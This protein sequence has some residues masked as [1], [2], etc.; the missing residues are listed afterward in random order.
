[1]MRSVMVASALVLLSGTAVLA[2]IREFATHAHGV[3]ALNVAIE[4]NTIFMELTAPAHDIVGFEYEAVSDEDR[5][6]ISRALQALSDPL[7]IFAFPPA[8]ECAAL[9]AFADLV[10]DSHDDDEHDDHD[11]RHDHDVDHDDDHHQR[12]GGGQ[13][14]EFHVRYVVECEELGA[15]RQVAVTYF[16]RFTNAERLEVQMISSR[17][18]AGTEVQR[19]APTLDLSGIL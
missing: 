6:A 14:S 11:D 16:D 1:M 8:A 5:A 12:G 18:T 9:E 13:H 4:D 3:G 10:G 15:V 7:A 17:G 19:E 2:Q